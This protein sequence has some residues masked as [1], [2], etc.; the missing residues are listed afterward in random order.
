MPIGSF[1]AVGGIGAVI[2]AVLGAIYGAVQ[3]SE[4]KIKAI[5]YGATAGALIGAA[6]V[7]FI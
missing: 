1:I 6:I 7:I 4:D 2:G 5:Y 3:Q